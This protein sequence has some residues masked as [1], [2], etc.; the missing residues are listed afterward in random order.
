MESTSSA[1]ARVLQPAEPEQLNNRT[2]VIFILDGLPDWQTLCE[3]APQGSGV[4]LLDGN[5]D[6]LK[7]M[8][9][10]LDAQPARSVDAIHLLSHGSNGRVHLGEQTLAADTIDAHTDVLQQIGA[11]LTEE[12]DFLLYGCHV[13]QDAAG[14]EFL[15]RLAQATGAD[16]AASDDATGAAELGGD[17]VLEQHVGEIDDTNSV[18]FQNYAALLAPPADENFDDNAGWSTGANSFTLD[19]ITYTKT[20]IEDT[21]VTNSSSGPLGDGAS[22]YYINFLADSVTISEASGANFKLNGF[23]IDA[24]ADADITLQPDSGAAITLVSNNSWVTQPVDLSANSDF[25]NITSVTISGSNMMLCMDDLDFSAPVLSNSPPS[26]GGAPADAVVT[27]DVDTPID[28]SAYD[29]FDENGDEITLT[30]AVDRGSLRTSD[31]NGTFSGVTVASSGTGS[32]TLTGAA[33]DLNTYLNDT[34]KIS[35]RTALDDTSSINLTVT[36]NDGTTDGTADTVALMVQQVNDDPTVAS[37]PA[38]VTVT[39]DVVSNFDLSAATFTDVDSGANSVTLTLAAGAGTFAATSGGGVTVGGSETGTLTLIGTAAGIDTYLN[40]ASNLQYTAA[41]NVNGTSATTVTLTANDGGN[42]GTGGGNNVALGSVNVDVTAVNDAPSLTSGDYTFTGVDEN[43]TSTAVAVSAMASLT[44][45]DAGASAG[46]AITASTGIGT[47][48]YSTDDGGSWTAVGAVAQSSALL[49]RST[50]SVRYVPDSQ[51]GETATFGFHAWDRTSGSYGQKV[52]VTTNGGTTAFST[53]SA[54]A[55]LDVS[56][57]NDA[58]SIIATTPSLGTTTEDAAATLSVGSFLSISDVDTG[59]SGGLALTGLTGNGSWEY[60]VDGGSIWTA[61]GAVAH[62]S[63]LL[64]RSTDVL[65]YLPDGENGETTTISYRAWDQ[66]SG[67]GGNK[68]D[69]TTNGGTTAFSANS[70]TASLAVTSVN[71]A[72]TFSGLDGA[73]AFTEVSASVGLDTDVTVADIELGALNGGNGNFAGA[74]LTLVRNGGANANDQFSIPSGGN[75]TVAGANVSA[76]GNVIATFDTSSPGQVVTTFANNGTIPTTALVSEVL[77]AIRYAN[78]A[79]DPAGTVQIDWTF[80]DGNSGNAQGTGG[81][82]ATATGST[83]VSVTNVND[84]PTLTATGQNPTFTEGAPG[85][86]LFSAVAASTVEAADRISSMT[87]TVTNLSD[88]ADEILRFDGSDLALVDGNSVTTATNGLNVSVSLAGSTATVSFSGATLTA[89]QM[90]ALVDGLAY[91]NISDNPATGSSRVVTIT[92]IE[93]DGGVENGGHNTAAPNLSSAVSLAAVN[94]APVIGNLAGDNVALQ[95]GWSAHIDSG[96]DASISNADSHDYNG[97]FLTIT[98]TGGNNTANGN[99]SVD[100]TN[101]TSGGDG[102]I[103][104]GETIQVGGVSIG[105]VHATNDGQGGNTLQVGFNTADATNARIETLL[106]NLR[107]SA[108][109][110]TGSQ[111]FTA[112]LN[113]SD[114]IANS[115]DQDTTANFTMTLGNQPQVTNLNGDSITFIE[116]GPVLLDVDSDAGLTD[117]D[118]PASLG[119]GNLRATISAGAAAAEDLLSVSGGGATLGGTTAG[120]NVSVGGTVIGTLANPVAAGNDF[121]VDFNADATLARVQTLIQ[122]LAYDNES[123]LPT[124]GPRTVSVTVT[125]NDGLTSDVAAIV[126]DVQSVNAAPAFSGVDG[127]PTFTEDGA[128]VVLDADMTV[129]DAELDS[130]DGN[131]GNYDGASI[132]LARIGTASA[133]DVFGHSGTLGALTE[134]Q[135]FEVGSTTIGTVTTNSGGTLV[136]SF[137]SNATSALVDSAIQQVTYSNV[138]NAPPANVEIGLSFNDGNA[139]A[140]GSGGALTDSNESIAITITPVNDAPLTAAGS[141]ANYRTGSSPVILLPE[142]V[143]TDADSAGLTTATVALSGADFSAAEDVL[144][145]TND[146]ATMGNITGSYDAGTGLMTLSSAGGTATPEQF[147]A[148]VRGVTFETTAGGGTT[149]TLTLQANDGEADSLAVQATLNVTAPPLPPPPAPEP[150]P[151]PEPV[152]PPQDEWENLPDEDGDGVPEL[153]EDF[154]PSLGGADGET[155]DGNGDSIPDTDQGDVTSVPFRQTSHVSLEP[156]APQVFVSLVADSVEGREDTGDANKAELRNAHQLDAPDDVPADLD[157]PLGMISFEADVQNA[158][159]IETFSLYV[160]GSLNVNGYWKQNAAGDWVNLASEAYGG[161]VVSEGG[162]IRLDFTIEDGGEFDEDGIANGIIVDPGAV[163]YRAVPAEDP[164]SV[165][166]L[167]NP[168]SNLH[169][170]TISE[171]EIMAT[172]QSGWQ[173][174]GSAFSFE[175]DG[176]KEIFRFFNTLSGDHFLTS[177]AEEA[178]IVQNSDWGYVYEGVVFAVHD[179]RAD[180]SAIHRYYNPGSGEHFY[181]AYEEEGI[182]AMGQYGFVYEGFLGYAFA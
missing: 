56:S 166:R 39:E 138:S 167:Y 64:L 119:G 182:E 67:S 45:P 109:A 73:P 72:P 46:I 83:T 2:E 26:L 107:W 96:E 89:A 5:G 106:Q 121:V 160:D 162:R 41:S 51:N 129:A 115:G 173:L 90:Q 36:P 62:S 91:R 31:G 143:I 157:M 17:W 65:R 156:D 126:V 151:G 86:D 135:A 112:T 20:G 131:A 158:G 94:D 4:V 18:H 16:V 13:A 152:M 7:Q 68:V 97:G 54:T 14:V 74:S 24:L 171:E 148:A 29:L 116:A 102:T 63:A 110:G 130:L 133:D 27:E 82:P 145:F 53:N 32:M 159:E 81:S 8:A 38:S 50:D 137:N 59:A 142:A 93:D 175:M 55:S 80:S 146:G 95:P 87:L 128:A 47:W 30:L 35:Y 57:V 76:G 22:D 34:N 176:E 154:V 37:L 6:V 1:C 120:S 48:Q 70:A 132:T 52:D 108:A 168:T 98:D 71:D 21:L 19:G 23:T 100:G 58:P 164:V 113:D 123:P 141:A 33:A 3:A 174:E 49:L 111:T 11:A 10:Y 99:F 134:G 85:A 25:E 124:T 172:T 150:E 69:V 165:M 155:G 122:A 103:A 101:V 170:Y 92:G 169:L 179:E 161:A 88:G 104:A 178:Q 147:Q 153:V 44:D 66:T 15:G 43:T 40:T 9:G 163:G 180:T 42:T 61:V 60:S 28:L 140:Q 181:T 117:S 12:G 144:A 177:N 139:G 114:G 136:L 75:L 118:N 127:T 79:D 84:A 125:D 149:R 77:Q 78:T 105:T